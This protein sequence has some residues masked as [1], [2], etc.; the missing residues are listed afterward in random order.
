MEMMGKAEG[1]KAVAERCAG[2]L[3]DERR[4][5]VEKLGH[6]ILS[7]PAYG[8][9]YKWTTEDFDLGAPLGRGK[10]GR[11]YIARDRYSHM[12]VAMKVMFKSELQKGRVERQVLREVEIQSRLKHPHILRLYTW[13]HDSDKIYLVLEYASEGELYKHLKN[14]PDG[15][16]DEHRSAKYTYQVASALQYC[17][18]NNVIH[19]DLKPENILLTSSDQVKLADFGWSAHTPSN[20]RKTLCGTLDYLPPEMVDGRSYDDSIDQWCLGVL[21]Y[22]FLAGF[23]PFES[24]STNLTYEK[25]RKLQVSF[26]RHFTAGAKDLISKLLQKHSSHRITLIQVMKHPWVKENMAEVN[27]D[28]IVI[29]KQKSTKL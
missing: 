24:E 26:P 28:T 11:V 18:M 6:R 25:I 17:H 29:E 20:K 21:C 22:E 23:P 9:K 4:R 12:V 8:A 3:D 10:F 15:H 14:S 27:N 5:E 2:I 1:A 19:R 7:H 16:F 13:F